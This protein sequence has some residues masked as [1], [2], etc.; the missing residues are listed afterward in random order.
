MLR[1]VLVAFGPALPAHA[2]A[3]DVPDRIQPDFGLAGLGQGIV[4]FNSNVPRH[5]PKVAPAGIMPAISLVRSPFRSVP[6]APE[7]LLKL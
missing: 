3:N 5:T 2:S 7:R 6:C 1:R 4:V